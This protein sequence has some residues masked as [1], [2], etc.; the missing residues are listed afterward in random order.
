MYAVF[1][2][3]VDPH[4]AAVL[5]FPRSLER[6][7]H[8]VSAALADHQTRAPH[9]EA[10]AFTLQGEARQLRCR[11]ASGRSTVTSWP[12]IQATWT[13]LPGAPPATG[14]ATT[15]PGLPTRDYPGLLAL[16]LLKAA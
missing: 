11:P 15:V 16:A 3:G 12:P 4:L 14:R 7:V 1:P 9:M 8:A 5:A 10:V 2:T 13:R 6:T